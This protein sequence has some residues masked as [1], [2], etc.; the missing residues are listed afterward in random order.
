MKTIKGRFHTASGMPASYRALTSEL[1]SGGPAWSLEAHPT[2][3]TL[4]SP[5]FDR[6]SCS[7]EYRAGL[8]ISR[9]WTIGNRWER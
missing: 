4:D 5:K 8:T 3:V 7:S 6:F 9:S 2:S 1:M